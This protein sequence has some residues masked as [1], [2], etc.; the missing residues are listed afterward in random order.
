MSRVSEER[1]KQIRDFYNLQNVL[2]NK[3]VRMNLFKQS[4][5]PYEVMGLANES[6]TVLTNDDLYNIGY[7]SSQIESIKGFEGLFSPTTY[8]NFRAAL[9]GAR[10]RFG[11]TNKYEEDEEVMKTLLSQIVNQHFEIAPDFMNDFDETAK[12]MNLT[13]QELRDK[14]VAYFDKNMNYLTDEQYR[15]IAFFFLYKVYFKLLSLN[16]MEGGARRRTSR[17]RRRTS[18]RR[19]TRRRSSYRR[20][21]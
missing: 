2:D 4:H 11:L 1:K 3:V 12:F 14:L 20:R 16:S 6:K 21:K 9:S 8:T 5:D 10:K 17:R 13:H 18:K 7:K 19:V 15:F